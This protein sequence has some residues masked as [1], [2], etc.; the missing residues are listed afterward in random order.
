MEN[1]WNK[2]TLRQIQKVKHLSTF[3]WYVFQMSGT[4]V[5]TSSYATGISSVTR[6]M[7][8]PSPPVCTSSWTATQLAF[9]LCDANGPNPEIHGTTNSINKWSISS[10]DTTQYYLNT[11]VLITVRI[12]CHCSILCPPLQVCTYA[13]T[14]IRAIFQVNFGPPQ[15]FFHIW[16]RYVHALEDQNFFIPP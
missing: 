1:L 2:F 3:G 11:R 10:N 15:F 5:V 16:S 6:L 9:T 8:S 14:I 12:H 13:H 7:S 4:Q